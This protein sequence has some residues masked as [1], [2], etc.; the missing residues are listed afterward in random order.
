MNK[1]IEAN[2]NGS[3]P[4]NQQNIKTNISSSTIKSLETL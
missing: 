2:N 1:N 4:A 3:E